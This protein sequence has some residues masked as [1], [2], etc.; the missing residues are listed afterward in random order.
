MRANFTQENI[1]QMKGFDPKLPMGGPYELP[2]GVDLSAA[3]P[4]PGQTDMQGT[5]MELAELADPGS[6]ARILQGPAADVKQ[7]K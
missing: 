4:V 7:L 1:E 2:S 6:S 3:R 5:I